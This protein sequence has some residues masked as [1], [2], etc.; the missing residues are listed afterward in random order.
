MT[1]RELKLLRKSEIVC[2]YIFMIKEGDHILNYEYF[3]AAP[4]TPPMR[5]INEICKVLE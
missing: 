4:W 2:I 1:Q 5:I 3:K